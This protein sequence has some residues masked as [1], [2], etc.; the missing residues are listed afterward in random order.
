VH[1]ETQH[2]SERVG[3]QQQPTRSCV[4]LCGEDIRHYSHYER[5][6][7]DAGVIPRPN[8]RSVLLASKTWTDVV[9]GSSMLAVPVGSTEQHGPHLPLDTDTTIAAAVAA[10]LP[11]SLLAPAIAYG[12]SGEHEGF[13]GTISI[14]HAAVEL[15]LLEYG[16]SACHW[17]DRL[18]FVN[19]HGGN[20]QPL[21]KAVLQL[22]FEGRDVA[23]LPCAVIGGDAHAG[24]TETS[25]MLHL[26][27]DRVR[28]D[29]A[30]PG[31][32]EPIQTLLPQLRSAGVAALSA[33][34][35]L[36]DP[37]GA[38][39]AEGAQLF[40]QLVDRATEA[41]ARWQPDDRGML[42]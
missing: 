22:R 23:W 17:A 39:A 33:N 31:N 2:R 20:A 25:L 24:R 21:A 4:R 13:A 37:T 5:L 15:L 29:R 27:P 3:S 16:R 40:D 7:W 34:G 42:R 9:S 6:R 12:A 11:Q 41:L 30:E 36:G 28:F 35:V 10:R 1:P 14:G 32:I 8:G 19:G 18:V 38:T 26:A